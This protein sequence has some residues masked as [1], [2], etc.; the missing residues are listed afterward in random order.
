[1]TVQEKLRKIVD[2]PIL[3]IES[4]MKVV[5]K[6]GKLVKFTLNPEQRYLLQN[7]DKYNIICK[8]RQLGMST[9]AA[10]YSIY[11][12]M[13]NPNITCLLMSYSID[14]ATGI[15]EK[16]KQLYNDLPHA[17]QVPLIANN[18]KELKF[19]NG[20]RIIVCTC[21]NK[22]A[23]R[24]LTISFAHV[25]EVAFC[26]DTIDKQLLAIEQC[27]TPNGKIILEST[28]NGMNFFSEIWSKAE[29]RDSM[30]KP[31]FFSWIDDKI[32][33]K[34]EYEM[35]CERYINLH[36][37]LPTVNELDDTEKNLYKQGATI[38]QLT[39]RRMKI[40]NSSEEAFC[41]EFPS[42]ATESF[43]STG[44]NVF[45]PKLIHE[46]VQYINEVKATNKPTSLPISLV[47]WFNR[48][49]T[50]WDTPKN[51]QKYYIGV[52]TGE[53]LSQDYSAF[54]VLSEDGIQ[55]AEFKSNKIK[56]FQYAEIVN[57]IGIYFN[58]ALLVVEKAS[59]GHSVVDKLRHD[60]KYSNMYKYKEYD[61]RGQAK[62]KVG[63]VTNQKSKS[64]MIQDFIELFE[65]NQIVINSKDLLNEMKMF[66]FNDGKMAATI[67]FHDD[68]VMSF[69][70]ALVGM[71]SKINYI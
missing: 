28:S 18:K 17:L 62:K 69:A 71:K 70:M 23:A 52:D 38:E 4:F 35:F 43:I 14:S 55:I 44:S 26:K 68:L 37:A 2:S 54:H 9:C 65:K 66:Q 63:F 11:L 50:M 64:I 25:S 42:N 56:P 3:Y 39:W 22:D 7:M 32:M 58:K 29:R 57:D 51:K 20:S 15:F 30:Y 34:E 46:R 16:L 47:P 53:G 12:A 27:L 59:A 1:M 40:A 48:G 67:G 41:Q 33:F 49:L 6:S 45:S 5:D 13:T 61:Q 19:T 8:S 10:A 24:S 31:F 36:G 60:Y 21:G